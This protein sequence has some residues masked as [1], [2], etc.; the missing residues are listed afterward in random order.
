MAKKN[1]AGDGG[2][3]DSAAV[4]SL[5]NIVHPIPVNL[6]INRWYPPPPLNFFT[7]YLGNSLK[8]YILSQDILL[9]FD[10]SKYGNL[11]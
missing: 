3:G 5:L 1:S 9:S 6:I 2:C 8:S 4:S 11:I 10:R 7:F